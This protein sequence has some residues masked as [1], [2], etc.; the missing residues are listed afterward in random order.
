MSSA[1]NAADSEPSPSPLHSKDRVLVQRA[2]GKEPPAVEQ[3]IERLRCVPRMLAAKNNQLGRSLRSDELEDLAQDTL[4]A[5]WRRLPE[6]SGNASLETWVF[7]FCYLELLRTLRERERLS[8]ALEDL[9][10]FA[11]KDQDRLSPLLFE[12]VYRRLEQ[13]PPDEQEIV[14]L[15]HLE[16]L[17]FEEIAAVLALSTSTAKT[18]YY[19]GILKLRR[20]LA[21]PTTAGH[22]ED[23]S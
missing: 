23:W 19:R 20:Q 1:M 15:K 14:R 13:L 10:H 8:P 11:E 2:L 12:D 7:R 16:D 5:I 17:T 4:Y 18:R 3:L 9:S 21:S 6:F 22:R